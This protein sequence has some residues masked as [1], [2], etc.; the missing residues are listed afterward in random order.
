[1]GRSPTDAEIDRGVHLVT[2]LRDE[3]HASADDALRYF[4]LMAMNLNEFMYVD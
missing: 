2:E 3:D 1:M 4:G